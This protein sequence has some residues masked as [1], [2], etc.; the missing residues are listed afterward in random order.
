MQSQID[1]HIFGYLFANRAWALF[2]LG[3][4]VEAEA[5]MQEACKAAAAKMIKPGA[6]GIHYHIGKALLAGGQ[7]PQ[8]MQHFGHASEIDPD[9]RHAA[10]SEAELRNRAPEA[11]RSFGGCPDFL[12]V[13]Y[14]CQD[15][16]RLSLGYSDGPTMPLS[17]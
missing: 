1:L 13:E 2:L 10:L 7:V 14:L 17:T 3:R 6:A 5:A 8:A 12:A 15:L 4:P 11:K 16:E 9:G